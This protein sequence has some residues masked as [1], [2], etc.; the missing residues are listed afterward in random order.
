MIFFLFLSFVFF[1]VE[2]ESGIHFVR[3]LLDFEI[4]GMLGY[5]RFGSV[6]LNCSMN[7]FMNI[8]NE[9][10]H[11]NIFSQNCTKHIVLVSE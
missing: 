9:Y 7:I 6:R 10:F 3:P 4:E 8:F 11:V 5:I 1:N 2:S